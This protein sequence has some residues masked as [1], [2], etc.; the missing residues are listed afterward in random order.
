MLSSVDLPEPDGPI[1]ATYS[2]A[3][4]VSVEVAQ[5]MHFAVAEPEH[6]LDAVEFDLRVRH[7]KL[8]AL[9]L[10]RRGFDHAPARRLSRLRARAR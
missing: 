7:R 1:T 10:A 2:P 6:A 8:T 4:I 5:R 3:S 9:S